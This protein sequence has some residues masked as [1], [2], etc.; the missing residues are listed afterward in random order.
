M[1]ADVVQ[2]LDE[3]RQK[4]STAPPPEE[5]L[6]LGLEQNT[7]SQKAGKRQLTDEDE[8]HTNDDNDQ[9]QS[10]DVVGGD[11]DEDARL[12]KELYD[13]IGSLNEELKTL[14]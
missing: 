5:V 13:L 12:E 3:K 2:I 1:R 6:E 4:R 9:H 7:L 11:D 8:G 10:E 14:V